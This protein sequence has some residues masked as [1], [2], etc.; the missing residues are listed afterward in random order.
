[1]A[2]NM[3]RRP[4]MP[5]QNV[6]QSDQPSNGSCGSCEEL[7][8][9][10]SEA[11]FFAQDLQLYLDTHPDDTRAVEMYVEAC[12]QYKACKAAFEDCFYPLTPCSAGREGEWNWPEGVWAPF[13]EKR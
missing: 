7:L 5:R 6:R 12:R 8:R 1:M 4:S 2:S 3:Y 11:A 9:A 10:V 13:I